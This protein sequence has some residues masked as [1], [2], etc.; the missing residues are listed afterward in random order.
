M[1][2]YT[3][4]CPDHGVFTA[5]ASINDY[6]KP[7]TCPDCGGAA[8]R[9]F[10]LPQYR[11]LSDSARH[12]HATNERAQHEPKSSKAGGHGSSCGC[13][14]CGTSK[15]KSRTLHRPDGSKSFP[16]ARPWMISH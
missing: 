6:D 10:S 5:F 3:Y 16:T 14:S 15:K 11:V 8:D 4:D 12:A 13:G 1:P 7:C 9:C 2:L